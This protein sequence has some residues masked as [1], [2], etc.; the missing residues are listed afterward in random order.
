MVLYHFVTDIRVAA[1][2]DE[3]WDVL[4]DPTTWPGWW[5]RLRRVEVTAPGRPDG[6]GM[7]YR[8]TVRAAL[9]YTLSF[10][11][12]TTRIR[13]PSYWEAR[14][15]GELQGTGLY[16]VFPVDGGSGVRHTWIVATTRPWM[17]LLAPVARPVFAW[18]HAVLMR[19]FAT[20]FAGRLGVRLLSA[21]E[22]VVA[23]GRP[24]FGRLAPS[25]AA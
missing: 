25:D 4:V 11:S 20:G 14:V 2:P 12:E 6:V 13:R 8:V 1:S 15:L 7:R 3:A 18:N 19:D 16:E 23:P 24:G 22:R 5:R 17:N 21:E 9:P 10:E